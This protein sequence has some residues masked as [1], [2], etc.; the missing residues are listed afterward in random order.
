MIAKFDKGG[1][2]KMN[3]YIKSMPQII[4]F[5]APRVNGACIVLS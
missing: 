3:D 5:F 4:G 2:G 1:F